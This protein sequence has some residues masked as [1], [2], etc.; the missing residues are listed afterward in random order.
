MK[1]QA[2]IRDDNKI[3]IIPEYGRQRLLTYAESFR[4]L[5][6]LFEGEDTELNSV[7]G[8]VNCRKTRDF[9]QSI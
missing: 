4:D 6:D 9:W 5:A 7:Y 1:K 2:E 8:S 3:T